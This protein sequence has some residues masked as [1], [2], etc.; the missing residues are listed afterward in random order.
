MQ[1]E[2]FQIDA[3]LLRRRGCAAPSANRRAAVKPQRF[4]SIPLR[5]GAPSRRSKVPG[6]GRSW[7]TNWALAHVRTHGGPTRPTQQLFRVA[8]T[9]PNLCARPSLTRSKGDIGDDP[10]GTPFL[11][12]SSRAGAAGRCAYK[13]AH[14]LDPPRSGL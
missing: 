5:G 3:Y 6:G 4:V 1:R 8:R 2:L 10:L 9:S 14:P 12:A 7:F 13:A 11:L